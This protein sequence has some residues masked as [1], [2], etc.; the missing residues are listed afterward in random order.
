MKFKM[1]VLA[2][3]VTL[4]SLIVTW[5][6]CSKQEKESKAICSICNT[7][8]PQT[9]KTLTIDHHSFNLGIYQ[10][11]PYPHFVVATIPNATEG[12][13]A[14]IRQ[15]IQKTDA[16]SSF[17]QLLSDAYV[18]VG[19]S[20]YAKGDVR[21]QSEMALAG[22]EAMSVYMYKQ[23]GLH[24]FLYLRGDK[25][26]FFLNKEYSVVTDAIN[27]KDQS[28]LFEKVVNA[29]Q[30]GASFSL[31]SV[32]VAPFNDVMRKVKTKGMLYEVLK[33]KTT[34]VNAIGGKMYPG[35]SNRCDPNVC[36]PIADNTP[37]HCVQLIGGYGCAEDEDHCILRSVS[38]ESSH[39]SDMVSMQ[40]T[41]Y[42][43]RDSILAQSTHGNEIIDRYYTAG[44]YIWDH[45][46]SIDLGR[47][48]GY[49]TL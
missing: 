3:A 13:S 11:S 5:Y 23:S 26:Q 14:A 38:N 18:P 49:V 7:T 2:L 40:S 19:Y 21:Q 42:Y 34:Q 15:M 25:G 24:H 31:I 32:A 28:L 46:G 41:F 37:S 39:S 17:N 43:M 12:N 45:L 1:P 36:T 10:K 35:D 27:F 44:S 33:K 9:T 4:S 48:Y 47:M 29:G 22:I 16:A 30:S 8:A 20:L 6:A